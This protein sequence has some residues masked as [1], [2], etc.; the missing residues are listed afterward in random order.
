MWLA[1]QHEQKEALDMF[2]QEIAPAGTGMGENRQ[3]NI[4]ESTH[5]CLCTCTCMSM[6][7]CTCTFKLLLL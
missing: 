7:N 5:V 3:T 4:H 6:Y 1:V 2:V